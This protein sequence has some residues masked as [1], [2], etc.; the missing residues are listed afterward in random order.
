VI[1]EVPTLDVPVCDSIIDD[2]R[3]QAFDEETGDSNLQKSGPEAPDMS[4]FDAAAI[5]DALH[6]LDEQLYDLTA[7]KEENHE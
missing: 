1:E 3:V 2:Y 6:T 4:V 5:N 7:Q